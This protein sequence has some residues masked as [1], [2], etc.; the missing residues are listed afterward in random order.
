MNYALMNIGSIVGI[1]KSA[2]IPRFSF[3]NRVW[4]IGDAAAFEGPIDPARK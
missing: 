1:D 3:P 4:K 2:S